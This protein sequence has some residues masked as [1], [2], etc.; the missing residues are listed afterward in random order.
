MH[1]IFIS[2]KIY[3][4]YILYAAFYSC[5]VLVLWSDEKCWCP[6]AA[7]SSSC[8]TGAPSSPSPSAHSSN[9]SI[10]K[11]PPPSFPLS[12]P[13]LPLPFPPLAPECL[14]MYRV[15]THP[16]VPPTALNFLSSNVLPCSVQ[17][18][19]PPSEILVG[20]RKRGGK[21]AL[22]SPYSHE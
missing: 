18:T 10:L 16:S 9:P 2:I 11:S 12:F 8:D 19:F 7:S 14:T 5:N 21:I 3:T 15:C 13:P 17:R 20:V 6:R 4:L 1:S 22:P